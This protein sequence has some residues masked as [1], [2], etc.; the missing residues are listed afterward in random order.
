MGKSFDK[1]L[2]EL[3]AKQFYPPAFAD[4]AT[5][6]EGTVEPWLANLY[7]ALAELKRR[8]EEPSAVESETGSDKGHSEATTS[9]DLNGSTHQSQNGRSNG[10]LPANNATRPQTEDAVPPSRPIAGPPEETQTR[11]QAEAPKQVSSTATHGRPEIDGSTSDVAE[12]ARDG[13]PAPG[14]D[15]EVGPAQPPTGVS[16]SASPTKADGA[17]QAF[18]V[19]GTGASEEDKT[20]K[21]GEV[22]KGTGAEDTEKAAE[23]PTPAASGPTMAVSSAAEAFLTPGGRAEAQAVEGGVDGSAKSDMNTLPEHR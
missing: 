9:S 3:G 22:G 7:P 5:N 6:M 11:P 12:G 14:R 19:R 10:S 17:K 2:R 4:E 18:A 20:V 16:S 21:D 13:V 1:R 15:R 8:A 23:P